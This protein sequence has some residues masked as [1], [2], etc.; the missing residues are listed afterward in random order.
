MNNKDREREREEIEYFFRNK[1]VRMLNKH[2]AA[3][4]QATPFSLVID[5][6][7]ERLSLR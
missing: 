5:H 4:R 1:I 2:C 6:S 7:A 3:G